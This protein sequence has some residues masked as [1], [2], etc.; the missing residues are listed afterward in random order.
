MNRLD[1]EAAAALFHRERISS[2]CFQ[3][4]VILIQSYRAREKLGNGG[5]IISDFL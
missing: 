3:L 5:R 2:A 4:T 1:H